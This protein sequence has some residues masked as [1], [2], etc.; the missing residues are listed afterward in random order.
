MKALLNWIDD[1]S[2]LMPAVRKCL[3][4]PVPGGACWC[5]V[6]PCT[7]VFSFCVQAITGFFLWMFYSPSAQTAWESV[8]FLQY[9]VAGGWLLRALHHWSGQVLLVLI[10][11]YLIQT[12]V[13]GKYRAP[14]ELVFWVALLMGLWTL[15][16]MLTGD[17]LIVD[18]EFIIQYRITD[19]KDQPREK[20][21]GQ[22]G[23]FVGEL[24]APA[25]EEHCRRFGSYPEAV[26]ADCGFH[27]RPEVMAAVREKV[28]TV[29]VPKNV[30]EWAGETF[31]QF[32]SFRA[33]IEGSIS[34]LKRAFWLARCLF[35]GFRNFASSVG[36]SVFC[37][38]LVLLAR[39]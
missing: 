8:Y 16:L 15:G 27:G 33:G 6:W 20:L 22:L 37:H 10:G 19:A 30:R 12:I 5:K 21:V 18:V 39:A 24:L 26:T 9:E 29:A 25:V 7:I 4:A 36:L 31:A 32:R 28:E 23:D 38:N 13:T 3:D 2:G 14:R 34:V 11:L 17:L 35:R 1:R